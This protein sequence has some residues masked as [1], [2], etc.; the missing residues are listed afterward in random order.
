MNQDILKKVI[1]AQ[2]N[3]ITEYNIYLK[4][5]NKTKDKNNKNVLNLIAK[6]ELKHYNFF[7]K[8]T[9]KEIKPNMFKVNIYL[10]LSFI[11]GL[12]FS[13]KLM[14]K[15]EKLA[16]QIYKL[17]VKKVPN[18]KSIL[19]DEQKHEKK[20]LSLLKEER[21]EYAGSLVLGLNDALVE[22]TGALAGLT[23]ALQN[24]RLIAITGL[25]T[26]FAASL[27]MAASNYLS[28]KEEVDHNKT[29]KPFKS[30]IY[31]GIS[32]IITV[33]LLI[34][35]YFIFKNMYTALII[36]LVISILI[37]LSY[38][39]YITVAKNLSFWKR[40]AEMALISLSVAV[41]SFIIGFL[42][43]RFL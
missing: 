42:V 2:K 11:F 31:T 40:F 3:E 25:I 5:A 20:I 34:L 28:S 38:T 14:E 33:I 36:M 16:Q 6:E 27:S 17:L 29:K 41:I 4:L 9:K 8:L 21:L 24:T 10:F 19:L 23:L 30:A 1:K 7:K 35:P 15:G 18:A 39:F 37:I 43:K 12:S 26:G 13:L 32:Y 22:L